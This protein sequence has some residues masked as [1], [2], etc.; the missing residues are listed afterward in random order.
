MINAEIEEIIQKAV[1]ELNAIDK[2]NFDNESAHTAADDILLE[3][4]RALGYEEVAE[5]Y[6]AAHDRIEFWYA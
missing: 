4:F 5:A 2:T 1:N 6:E 3:T